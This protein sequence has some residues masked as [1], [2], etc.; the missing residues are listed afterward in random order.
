MVDSTNVDKAKKD[1]SFE[2]P[3][4][5]QTFVQ[6]KHRAAAK[7]KAAAAAK[8]APQP[9]TFV[10]DMATVRVFTT[11]DETDSITHPNDPA[12]KDKVRRVEMEQVE[13]DRH[14]K[15]VANANKAKH[16]PEALKEQQR[17]QELANER[18][19]AHRLKT[20]EATKQAIREDHARQAAEASSKKRKRTD[21]ADDGEDDKVPGQSS[22]NDRMPKKARHVSSTTLVDAGSKN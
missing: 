5:Q 13:I 18:E 3:R 14:N 21:N 1:Q 7:M 20:T 2:F 10:P 15:A 16:S 11:N 19:R 12:A 6:A 8:G 22:S 4:T 17:R 9:K